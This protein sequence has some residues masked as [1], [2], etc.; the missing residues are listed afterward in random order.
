MNPSISIIIPHYNSLDSVRALAA[1]IPD[2][3][4][5][6]VILVDDRSTVDITPL[7]ELADMRTNLSLYVNDRPNKGAGTSRNIGLNH[8]E[9]EWLLFADADDIFE[10]GWLDVVTP[11]LSTENDLVYFAPTSRN[12]QTGALGARHRHYEELVQRYAAEPGEKRELELR[13]GFYTPWSKL[14]RRSVFAENNIQFDEVMVANDVMAMTKAAW[15]SKKITADPRTIYCVFCG[16]KTLTSKKSET[17]FDT[18]IRVKINRY[19]FLRERLTRKQLNQTHADYYMAGSLADAVMGKWG[20]KK[21][22]EVIRA[23]RENKVRIVS[24]EMLK[25]SFLLHYI[26]MDLKWRKETNG[27]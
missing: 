16:E 8:A 17:N 9:G 1:S 10:P 19:V 2:R 25:P 14:V 21:V 15:Y 6:Q 18:R 13:Y 24:L 27:K 5:I 3:E 22:S 11:Y 12:K 7:Q 23:Y 26:L 4:D 20:F